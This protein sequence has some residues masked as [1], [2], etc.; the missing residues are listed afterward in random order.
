MKNI[1]KVIELSDEK[2]KELRR[3][4]ETGKFLPEEYK[5][6]YEQAKKTGHSNM[7]NTFVCMSLDEYNVHI[8]ASQ[9]SL[10]EKEVSNK[11][12]LVTITVKGIKSSKKSK[13]DRVGGK[14]VKCSKKV[15]L[16]KNVRVSNIGKKRK[17]L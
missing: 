13:L 10:M 15:T 14:L 9:R 7:A 4:E 12:K 3:Y 17:G 16:G 5:D 6:M 8:K 11:R 1:Q 2:V